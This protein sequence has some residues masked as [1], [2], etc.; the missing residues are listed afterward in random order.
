MLVTNLCR[1]SFLLF[2]LLFLVGCGTDSEPSAHPP[3][4]ST[5][6]ERV[7]LMVSAAASLSDAMIEI[8]HAFETEHPT[9]IVTYTFGSS[10][11][12]ATQIEQGAPSDL[13]LSASQTDM[14]RLQQHQLIVTPSRTNFTRNELALITRKDNPMEAHSF[15]AIASLPFTHLAIGEPESVPAGR[16]AMETLTHLLIWDSVKD[17]LVFASDVRQ[18]LTYVESG[19]ADLGI[20]YK[21]DV[22]ASENVKVIGVASPK[23][24]KPISYPGAILSTTS[25][26][27]TAQLF[28]DFVTGEKGQ[29]I[30]TK[31]GFE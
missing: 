26:Q 5:P 8:K 6:T 20:V 28:L 16:Y 13:F 24:H 31:Y 23:W 19:N 10:G 21:T 12:L 14:D 29:A 3:H 4:S 18:V 11:K 17:K 30:L 1:Y 9:V 25:H 7:E 27:T 22:N 2:L 15:E